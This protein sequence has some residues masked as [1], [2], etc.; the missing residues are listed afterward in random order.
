MGCKKRRV[1]VVLG[2]MDVARAKPLQVSHNIKQ[3]VHKTTGTHP[4]SRRR[5]PTSGVRLEVIF[6]RW[7]TSSRLGLRRAS[8]RGDDVLER[9]NEGSV[10][11]VSLLGAT[12]TLK[13]LS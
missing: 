13:M 12:D 1:T 6:A 5:P 4:S 8:G 10:G 7:T 3:L 11:K 2:E 9:T